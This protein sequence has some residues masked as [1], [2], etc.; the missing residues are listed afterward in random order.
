MSQL[1]E[2]LLQDIYINAYIL[3]A[4]TQ[5]ISNFR[6]DIASLAPALLGRT[7]REFTECYTKTQKVYCYGKIR[8]NMLRGDSYASD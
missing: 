5:Q 3:R 6:Y 7:R 2:Y 8:Y 4:I 1:I